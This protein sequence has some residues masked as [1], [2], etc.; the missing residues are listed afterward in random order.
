MA[1]TPTKYVDPAMTPAA[2]VSG[3]TPEQMSR[4]A[5]QQMEDRTRATAMS[6]PGT[7]IQGAPT[8]NN[9]TYQA[10]SGVYKPET[11]PYVNTNPQGIPPPPE[12]YWQ[13]TPQNQNPIMGSI[14]ADGKATITTPTIGQ[15]YGSGI[16]G[17]GIGA[18]MDAY[19]NSILANQAPY[20]ENKIRQD[21][22]NRFQAEI[23]ALNQYYGEVK[24]QKQG[25]EAV[26]G[27]ARLGTGAAIQARRGM[28]G[29]DFGA[30]QTDKT[31]QYNNTVQNDIARQV[32]TERMNAVAAIMGKARE[33]SQQ[34]IAAKK[35]AREKSYGDYVNFLNSQQEMIDKRAG[36]IVA[37][38]IA[39]SVEPTD[40]D[41]KDAAA[42]SGI[43]VKTLKD[44]YAVQ[45][46][47]TEKAA[48]TVKGADDI[49]Y[50]LQKDGTYKAV[51]PAA[52]TIDKL[53]P[54]AAEYEYAKK[55][56]YAGSFTDYQNE[57][58]NRKVV[59]EKAAS[60]PTSY[61]EWDLAGR[62]GTFESWLD[63]G[64]PSGPKGFTEATQNAINELQSGTPW[65]AAWGRIKALYP[66]V[67]NETID[68]A[69][70]T[71]WKE[72]GAY[73]R[74]AEEQKKFRGTPSSDPDLE[75][76]FAAY[77]S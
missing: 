54:S 72:A 34:E 53:P 27:E 61:K 12:K 17:T 45:K 59:A 75:A 39:G 26:V 35:A 21:T 68:A 7:V 44:K 38:L 13:T 62:P 32:D 6:N 58:A 22:M 28:L 15:V 52:T 64:S 50:Q 31:M 10:Y 3:M 70:G 66:D 49:I 2:N 33:E 8:A 55:N 24:R 57:D 63:K 71:Q 37:A 18:A 47:E 65:G 43:D 67:P 48:P 74:Y 51:T 76:A 60:N 16:G 1:T 69:L 36:N 14:G 29:S 73:Q 77:G 30:A 42:A 20:D 40:Q 5:S 4:Q 46:K 19:G 41:L 23:D 9:T 11:A 56:G 25:A